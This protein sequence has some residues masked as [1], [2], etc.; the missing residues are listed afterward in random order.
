MVR[1]FLSACGRSK[2]Y[3]GDRAPGNPPPAGETLEVSVTVTNTGDTA[4]AQVVQVVLHIRYGQNTVL[5]PAPFG[6]R[7][8]IIII[9]DYI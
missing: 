9:S 4:G 8:P 1:H 5:F 3:S 7:S 2:L 6:P